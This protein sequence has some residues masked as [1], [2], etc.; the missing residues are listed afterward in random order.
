M[1]ANRYRDAF[2]RLKDK[3]AFGIPL[4]LGQIPSRHFPNCN[5]ARDFGFPAAFECPLYLGQSMISN[6]S[7]IYGSFHGTRTTPAGHR[8]VV[9]GKRADTTLPKPAHIANASFCTC[10][11]RTAVW[12][13]PMRA[14]PGSPVAK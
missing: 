14:L 1:P 12:S 9:T 6:N 4:P 10:N 7:T 8:F 5:P 13:Q 2:D 11:R 3:P